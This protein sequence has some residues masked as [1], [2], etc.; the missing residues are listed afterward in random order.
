MAEIIRIP[1]GNAFLLR[2]T[3]QIRTGDYTEDADFSVVT[4]MGVNFVRR[5]RIAQTFGLDSLG[6]IVIENIGN[7]AQGVYGVELY[8]YYHG[9]PWRNYQKNVFQIVNENA[10]SDPGSDNENVLTYDVTFDV[11]FGGDGISAAFVEATVATHN[12][13]QESHPDLR[14]ELEEK[15][16]DVKVGDTSVVEDGVAV[17]DLSGKQDVINDLATIRSGAAAGDTAYQKPGTGIPA[18][19]LSSEVQDMIENGGKTKSVSVNGGTPVTPDEN[20]Q[21]DLTIEQANVTIGTVTTGAAGSN[22][23]V[24][25]SGTGTAPVLDFVIPKGDTGDTGP[26]GPQGDSA[27]Y[28]PDDS[29]TPDFVMANTTGQS[30][31]KAMTQKAVTDELEKIVKEEVAVVWEKGTAITTTGY[32]SNTKNMISK[33]IVVDPSIYAKIKIQSPNS[34]APFYVYKSQNV[35]GEEVI[36][37]LTKEND[38]PY[39]VTYPDAFYITPE[40]NTRYVVRVALDTATAITALTEEDYPIVQ[41]FYKSEY[42]LKKTE[43]AQDYREE[44]IDLSLYAIKNGVYIAAGDNRWRTGVGNNQCKIIPINPGDKIRVVKRDTYA[45]HVVFLTTN[46]Y[47]NQGA[48]SYAGGLT[49]YSSWPDGVTKVAPEDA[50]FLYVRILTSG[51]NVTPTIYK[52]PSIQDKIGAVNLDDVK[53]KLDVLTDDSVVDEFEFA[54]GCTESSHTVVSTHSVP[55]VIG[56]TYQIVLSATSWS[57]TNVGSSANAFWVH[58]TPDGSEANQAGHV[59]DELT[60]SQIFFTRP[61]AIWGNTFMFV[62][63]NNYVVFNF[64]GDVGET[65]GITVQAVSN[66]SQLMPLPPQVRDLMVLKDD[67]EVASFT[68]NG[69]NTAS[70]TAGRVTRGVSTNV[71]SIYQISLSS[72]NWA[73]TH[74]KSTAKAFFVQH[75]S[76]NAVATATGYVVDKNTGTSLKFT[77]PSNIS[78]SSFVFKAVQPYIVFSFRGDE[79]ESIDITVTRLS[80]VSDFNKAIEGID[81]QL[82]DIR[83]GIGMSQDIVTL[84]GGLTELDS[85]FQALRWRRNQG[86][87]SAG[88]KP[89]VLLHF[90]DLHG[91]STHLNR[92][93]E[94]GVTFS[95]YIDDILH[96]G[97]TVND[98][99]GDKNYLEDLEDTYVLNVIGNHDN[100]DSSNKEGDSVN[101]R[102][103]PTKVYT[104]FIKPFADYQ[105]SDL[106]GSGITQPDNAETLGLCYYHK[107]YSDSKLRLIVLDCMA[108]DN[109]QADWFAGVLADAQTNG[110][111]VLCADHYCPH[112]SWTSIRECTFT[113]VVSGISTFLN[114]AAAGILQNAIDNGLNFVCWLFGHH[115]R[116]QF[117]Y[118]AD[119]PSQFALAVDKAANNSSHERD[120]VR[121]STGRTVDCFNIIAVDTTCK[122]MTV[123]RI[124]NNRDKFMRQ[125]NYLVLDYANGKI[126]HNS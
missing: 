79:G 117:G 72:T 9:E 65:L 22:A 82:D 15:V 121:I 18:S 106:Q 84:N 17:I 41:R 83:N 85:K 1:D 126:L 59:K 114:A 56:R 78:S 37:M 108:W 66:M 62:A 31:T 32:S 67:A 91:Y 29:D 48:V 88:N 123:M 12:G 24:N 103:L 92:I 40:A 107:D 51:T 109:A 102:V 96:T 112:S 119:Y 104:K 50:H 94:F 110:F 3:G 43:S 70:S 8:G 86:Q 76:S 120:S 7:L 58:H 47:S 113:S 49:R 73:C 74:V 75:C 44:E 2:V 4:H 23:E 5:G 28:N 80:L 105:D 20:G 95:S 68:L 115:H 10:N 71:G 124:G 87:S 38:E 54:G 6:R 90:S 125:K 97:D 118:L 35:D 98:Q 52:I 14:E 77:R 45:A 122:V 11:T 63:L 19:D 64:R 33:E 57:C 55:T 89:C 34:N 46:T 100:W 69:P 93:L 25:N 16:S 61:S 81:A 99:F 116:D 27:V 13:D 111:T 21:V 30:T 36:E 101:E 60:G 42:L 53:A 26:Q 39:M